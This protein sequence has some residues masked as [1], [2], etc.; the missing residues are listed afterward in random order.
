M[1]VRDSAF[2]SSVSSIA[3]VVD[4]NLCTGCGTCAFMQPTDLRMIDAPAGRRP[5]T[6]LTDGT[7]PSTTEALNA[8][9]GMSLEHDSALPSGSIG[10]LAAAWGPVLEVWEGYAADQQLRFAASSGGAATA[11]SLY[12]LDGEDMKGVLH[13]AAR[14][15]IPY[16]NRTVLSTTRRE[17]LSATGSRYAPASPCDG[18][19]MIEGASGPCVFIGKPCDVAGVQKARR[20][21]PELDRRIGLTI[22]IF[23]AGTPTTEGT[24]ELARALG[25]AD[26]DAISS[27]RYRGNGWPGAAEIRTKDGAVRTM[28][29][30]ES[31]GEILQRHTQWRCSVC[32]D[33]TGEFADIAVGDPWYREIPPGEPGRSLVVVRTARGREILRNAMASG[34]LILDRVDPD[35]LPASQP[36]L[37]RVRG[38]IWGR[39][40]ALRLLNLATPSFRNMPTFAIWLRHL[41]FKQKLQ[42]VYGT[43]KRVFTKRL[44][45]AEPVR[46]DK[47]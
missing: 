15:D 9:P 5:L 37:L 14:R 42:S 19:H 36:N 33:H 29:Y 46:F 25:I 27:V 44:F 39:I 16:L 6:I 2:G 45:R 12:C 47:S 34:W 1:A 11:I 10:R 32:A 30:D 40:L 31:W 7:M 24:L 13:T 22:G 4:K 17:L 3:D 35:V 23:C 20:L 41:S 43:V 38:S 28:S 8:C 26:S 18:L 21:R